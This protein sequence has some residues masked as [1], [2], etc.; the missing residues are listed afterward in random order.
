MNHTSTK[1]P[2][3]KRVMKGSHE[4]SGRWVRCWNCGFPID[5]TKLQVYE[6]GEGKSYQEIVGVSGPVD[7]SNRFLT[8]EVINMADVLMKLD[9]SGSTTTDYYT[10]KKVLVKSGCPQCGTHN[11]SK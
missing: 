7:P 9:A 3:R 11:L 6:R 4:D 2:S 5:L 1:D 8:M 10:P